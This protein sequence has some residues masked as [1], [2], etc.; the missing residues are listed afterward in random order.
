M[1][2]TPDVRAITVRQPWATTIVSWG[3]HKN[4][5]N[6]GARFPHRWRGLLLIHAGS[7]WSKRGAAAPGV[8]ANAPDWCITSAGT[9]RSDVL[10][11]G[12]VIGAT[13]LADVHPDGDCCRP[14]G[15]SSYTEG[16]GR[17]VNAVTHLVLED[18]RQVA[19]PVRCP[20][21]LGLWTPTPEVVDAVL[22]QLPEDWRAR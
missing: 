16:S 3:A 9:V 7:A 17:T 2:A 12:A 19:R 13:W 14:W 11:R 22:A 10:P 15:E 1:I 20:G 4:V 5:E 18:A 6:R 21:A 8:V